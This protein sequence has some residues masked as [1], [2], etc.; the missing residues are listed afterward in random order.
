MTSQTARSGFQQRQFGTLTVIGWT[1]E[2]PEDQRD[3]PFLLVYSLGDGPD[4]PEAGEEALRAMLRQVGLPIGTELMDGTADGAH[5]PVSLMVE[6]GQAVVTMPHF[7]AQY[8]ATPEWLR[9]VGERGVAYFMFATRPWP[10]GT[11]GATV[12]EDA[13][14]GFVSEEMMAGAAHCLLPVRALK[15]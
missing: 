6:G 11:P 13:L 2:H 7:T 4:G 10:E 3:M 8:P 5:L 15:R 1:G 9:A 14:R 12:E